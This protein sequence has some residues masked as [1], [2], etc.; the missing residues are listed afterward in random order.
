MKTTFFDSSII[1]T[2]WIRVNLTLCGVKEGMIAMCNVS[3][4]ILTMYKACFTNF[5]F[6]RFFT[7][8][9]RSNMY[10]PMFL[11]RFYLLGIKTVILEINKKTNNQ[12]ITLNWSLG[13]ILLIGKTLKWSYNVLS[14]QFA[15]YSKRFR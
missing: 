8:I 9:N 2:F 14:I 10:R 11:L 4:Q 3:I 1:F 12:K 13:I 7:Y 15:V 6:K 5:A